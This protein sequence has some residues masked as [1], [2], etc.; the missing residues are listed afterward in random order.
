MTIF[1]LLP[2]ADCKFSMYKVLFHTSHQM[3]QICFQKNSFNTVVPYLM[4]VVKKKDMTWHLVIMKY[5]RD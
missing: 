5:I 3:I 1:K 4:N 2:A